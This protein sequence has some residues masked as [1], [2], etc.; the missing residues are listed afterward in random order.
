MTTA[1]L[2]QTRL[3]LHT[4][5][6]HKAASTLFQKPQRIPQFP[7]PLTSQ[8]DFQRLS[9]N[10]QVLL[11]FALLYPVLS[12][13]FATTQAVI[14]AENRHRFLAAWLT[15]CLLLFLST[16]FLCTRADKEGTK[17]MNRK[18]EKLKD[19]SHTQKRTTLL[20]PAREAAAGESHIALRKQKQLQPWRLLSG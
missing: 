17:R 10:K 5:L 6:I 8:Q 11:L 9:G 4:Q 14:S 1:T 16:A 3:A 13:L 20:Q 7:F 2:C 18:E 19:I 12:S 15:V